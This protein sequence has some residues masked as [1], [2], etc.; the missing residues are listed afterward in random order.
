MLSYRHSRRPNHRRVRPTTRA[1]PGKGMG[2]KGAKNN[3][4]VLQSYV[5]YD[6]LPAGG[7]LPAACGGFGP[8]LESNTMSKQA[9]FAVILKMNAMFADLGPDELQRIS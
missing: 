9:E 5:T 8:D 6:T 7:F 1:Y 4:G 3:P 2:L